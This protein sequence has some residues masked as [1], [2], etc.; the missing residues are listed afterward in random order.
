MGIRPSSNERRI[1]LEPWTT[2]NAVVRAHPETR[3]VFERLAQG[4]RFDWAACLDEVAWSHGLEWE[5]L[6][7]RLQRAMAEP[8]ALT[9]E[10]TADERDRAPGVGMAGRAGRQ[11]GAGRA[12]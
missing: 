4:R 1:G 8:Q 9:E 10:G 6:V 7:R 12:D 3:P 11:S 5:Q 2:P